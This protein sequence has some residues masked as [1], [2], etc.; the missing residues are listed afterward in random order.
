MEYGVVGG[1]ERQSDQAPMPQCRKVKVEIG[2]SGQCVNAT[3]E[4]T[5]THKLEFEL[6]GFNISY[7]LFQINI[8]SLVKLK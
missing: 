7:I 8:L 3:A 4:L 5:K 6:S 1:G 2:E